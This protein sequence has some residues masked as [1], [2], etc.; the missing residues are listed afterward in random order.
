M[1]ECIQNMSNQV[2]KTRLSD[3]H[4][5]DGQFHDSQMFKHWPFVPEV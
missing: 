2:M 1:D 5:I 3:M 4:D